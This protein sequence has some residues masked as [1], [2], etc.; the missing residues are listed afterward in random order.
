[1]PPPS[2]PAAPVAPA[3][4]PM[5]SAILIGLAIAVAIICESMDLKLLRMLST[6]PLKSW[7]PLATQSP[8]AFATPSTADVSW[9]LKT[10]AAFPAASA[11]SLTAPAPP[12]ALPVTPSRASARSAAASDPSS[13]SVVA[14]L[15]T[16]RIAPMLSSGSVATL[17][18]ASPTC[19][20]KTDAFPA[21]VAT[22]RSASDA[23]DVSI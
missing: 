17:M 6:M 18:I 12:S 9:F 8:N 23:P 7:K 20:S 16:S 19:P 1:M 11:M 10:S 3:P 14:S 2:P 22:S 21:S 5:P 13:I 4:P 15:I